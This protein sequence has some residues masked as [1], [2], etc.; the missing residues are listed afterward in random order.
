MSQQDT[1]EDKVHGAAR[2]Y[3]NFGKILVK[4]SVEVLSVSHS[5]LVDIWTA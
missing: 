3:T 1:P 2:H 4:R 5:R